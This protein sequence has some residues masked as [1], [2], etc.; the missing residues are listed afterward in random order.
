MKEPN[1]KLQWW[2]IKLNEFDYEIE[3]I[4]VKDNKVADFLS[5]INTDTHQI[6]EIEENHASNLA[7]IHSGDCNDHIP[8][9]ETIINKYL[10]Q[11][12][13]VLEK[14]MEIDIIHKRYR[15]IF[16]S[17]I[18]LSDENY[19]NNLLRKTIKK[20]VTGIYSELEN[21]KYNKLQRKLIELFSNDKT[22]RFIKCTRK[23]KDLKDAI[24]VIE[25]YHEETNHRGIN[26]NFSEIK[27]HYY[28]PKL[29]ELIHKYPRKGVMC[30]ML[31]N[32]A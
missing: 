9:I 28:Y 32:H 29:K 11:I 25:K 4:K 12:H 21:P 13:L 27:D 17:E 2:R 30:D 19:I 10:T 8:I 22:V 3:Y 5:R 23:A 7:T 26:E 15:R 24:K 14:T 20:G 18:E 1:S 31:G 16:I 6:N